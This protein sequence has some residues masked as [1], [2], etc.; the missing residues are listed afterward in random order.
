MSLGPVIKVMKCLFHQL[1][2]YQKQKAV[3]EFL[4][5]PP[6]KPADNKFIYF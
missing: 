2:R 4:E 1:E 3:A 6:P 5:S